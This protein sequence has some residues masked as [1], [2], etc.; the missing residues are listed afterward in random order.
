M[1]T[2][3]NLKMQESTTKL[4][5]IRSVLGNLPGRYRNKWHTPIDLLDIYNK[6]SSKNETDTK[7]ITNAFRGKFLQ[8]YS[9]IRYMN[10]RLRSYGKALHLPQLDS[11]RKTPTDCSNNRR[12]KRINDQ[13]SSS[14][15][16]DHES[17]IP[18]DS[19][20]DSNSSIESIK[21]MRQSIRLIIT[22]R[23]L[24]LKLGIR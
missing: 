1:D 24:I 16:S 11:L 10:L 3:L 19:D 4:D 15:D 23:I 12:S 17:S 13:S 20:S 21:K 22:N 8:V 6:L 9:S 18:S 5:S 14:S 7:L 2:N